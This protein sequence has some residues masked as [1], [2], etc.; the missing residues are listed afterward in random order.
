MM[1]YGNGRFQ[2]R[3]RLSSDREKC[4]ALQNKSPETHRSLLQPLKRKSS[5]GNIQ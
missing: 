2:A 1:D 5:G 3:V 4:C